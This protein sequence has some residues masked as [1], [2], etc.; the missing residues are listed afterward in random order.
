MIQIIH[1]TNGKFYL[2]P[3]KLESEIIS[4]I[5]DFGGRA[6]IADIATD[7]GIDF[8]IVERTADSILDKCNLIKLQGSI[9]SRL[10]LT[11][12]VICEIFWR[13]YLWVNQF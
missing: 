13:L 10:Y 5:D 12:F 8:T 6:S 7:L 2:T 3:A 9:K 11:R 4:S 1:S